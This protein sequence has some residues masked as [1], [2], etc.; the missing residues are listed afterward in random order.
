MAIDWTRG[1]SAA[2]RAYRVDLRTWTDAEMV[3]GIESLTVERTCDGNAS[4]LESA[5]LTVSTHGIQQWSECYV[6]VAM[7][8][9]Q[10]GETERVDVATLLCSS[11][12]GETVRGGQVL[13]V[14]GRSVLWPAS[15][16]LLPAGSYAPAGVDAVAYVVSMLRACI[17]A[18]IV[19]SG[20]AILMDAIVFD[21]GTSV[22]EAAWLVL[23]ACGYTMR[24]DGD[25]TVRI[26]PEPSEPSIVLDRTGARLMHTSVK[27]SLDWSGVPNRYYAVDGEQMACAVN[28]DPNSITS[29]V[30]RGY[31][32]DVV[33][34]SPVRVGGETLDA[35]CH[36]KLAE[37]SMAY[38]ERTYSR[39]Y[40]PGVV[41]GDIVRATLPLA[42][43]D[44]DMRITRQSL[45]CGAGIVVEEKSKME[46][47]S[48]PT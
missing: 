42:G 24:I 38:D 40:V 13:D 11:V 15:V 7:L 1:Y 37:A 46:V 43:L 6:R 14:D 2:W 45:T 4:L 3:G 18:P 32:V 33:D 25:G 35:Y 22:L 41:P 21:I 19:A 29:T 44:G 26:G 36:R 17:A 9:T 5:S 39:E 34:T 30:T 23:R 48:W 28:D 47:R 31:V 27:Q 8:A 20:S 10:G 12:S 16:R